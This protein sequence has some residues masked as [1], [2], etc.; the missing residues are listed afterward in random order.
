M[1]QFAGFVPRWYV[2]GTVIVPIENRDLQATQTLAIINTMYEIEVG[3]GYDWYP[4]VLERG[5]AQIA[6]QLAVY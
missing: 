4:L 3:V 6:E 2:P 1:T 5:E